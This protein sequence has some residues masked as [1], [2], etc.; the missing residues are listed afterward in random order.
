M[1]H[2]RHELEKFDETIRQK[3]NVVIIAGFD[4]AGR[5]P[6]CGPVACGGCILPRDYYFPYIDDSKKLTPK[7]RDKAFDEIKKVALAYSV[8]LISPKDIDS[9]NILEASRLGMEKCLSEIQKKMKID[10]IITDY[11]KLHTDLP[12]LAIPKGDATS[13]AV[14]AASILAK[15]TRDRYMEEM[16]KVYPQYGFAKHKGYPTKSHLEALRKY[17]VIKDFY[18]ESY[19]PVQKILQE[20]GYAKNK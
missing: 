15:V 9:I 4:E 3:N 7:E 17:G 2:D 1:I 18:R 11:M 8:N 19:K 6:L 10:F 12:V 16:D 14:A 13:Q 20:V 5:G